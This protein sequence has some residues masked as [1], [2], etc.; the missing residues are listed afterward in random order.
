MSFRVWNEIISNSPTSTYPCNLGGH[1][2]IIL[3]KMVQLL[4]SPLLIGIG[5]F[6]NRVGRIG[7]NTKV[8]GE[9]N[10]HQMMTAFNPH[11]TLN[12]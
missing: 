6:I 5:L 7:A 8:T 2:S 1:D 12:F 9:T 10:L 11:S 4:Q 3:T